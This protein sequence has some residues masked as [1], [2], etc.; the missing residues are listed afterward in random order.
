LNHIIEE[1][2]STFNEDENSNNH[3]DRHFDKGDAPNY[4]SSY[5]IVDYSKIQNIETKCAEGKFSTDNSKKNTLC[6]NTDFYV[7]FGYNTRKK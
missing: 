2:T 6:D 5:S 1:D 7:M 3:D 4:P